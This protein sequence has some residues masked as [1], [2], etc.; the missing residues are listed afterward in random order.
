MGHT[1]LMAP[2]FIN[3]RLFDLS[4]LGYDDRLS[5]VIRQDASGHREMRCWSFLEG[6]FSK[7]DVLDMGLRVGGGTL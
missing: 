3:R 5:G 1:V 2:F 4:P 6:R 7:N